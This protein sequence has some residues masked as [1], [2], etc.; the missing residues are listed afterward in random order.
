MLYYRHNS[1]E[2]MSKGLNV[3]LRDHQKPLF[4]NP[5][6]FNIWICHRRFGKT[7]AAVLK[8]LIS[9]LVNPM[10]RPQYAYLLPEGEQAEKVA[11]PAF[12]DLLLD[13]PG[14][15]IN[16]QKKTIEIE[17]NRAKI[18]VLG[19][20]EPDRLRGM[21]FDGV[22]I[23]EFGD[24]NASAWGEVIYPTLTDRKG[25]A[26][27]TGTP[28]G[29]DGLY[30][31]YKIGQL[32]QKENPMHWDVR[33][34]DVYK[35]NVFTPEEIKE[36]QDMMTD[37]QFRQEYLLD[38]DADFNNRYYAELVNKAKESGRVGSY[39][40]NPKLPVHVSYDLGSDGTA[41]WFCQKEGNKIILIDYFEKKDLKELSQIFN[42][43]N[44]KGYTYGK[45]IL[46]HDAT[47][48][49]IR[50]DASILTQ[51]KAQGL[52]CILLK[53]SDRNA[54]IRVAQNN[55]VRCYFDSTA[56]ERGLDCLMNYK[57]KINRDGV[58]T[59]EPQHDHHSHGADAF[60]YLMLEIDNV[61]KMFN[62]DTSMFKIKS[63]YNEFD[64]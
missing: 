52:S 29:K 16:N 3:S 40:Y 9:A 63:D 4:E 22:V 46:P 53:R 1:G 35:S 45:H 10:T 27:I 14:F 56:C 7:W 8:T 37:A 26:V 23:D 33:L 39:G 30:E 12:M 13:L 58:V 54:G 18:Y 44:N 50:G 5:K 48:T 42:T 34:I 17:A 57:A 25:W 59:Q 24:V 15:K 20:K 43:L 21:Y 49:T 51:F 64:F 11:W 47:Q 55:F 41:L 60:R 2:T 32:M 28:K 38:F 19:L 31:M 62:L 36:K 61:G 6:R